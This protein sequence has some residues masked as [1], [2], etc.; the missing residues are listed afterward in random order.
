M[1]AGKDTASKKEYPILIDSDLEFIDKAKKHFDAKDYTASSIYIRKELEKIV[2]ERLP[3]ELKY[4]TDGTFLSLQTLWT[5]LVG[6]FSALGKPISE[7]TKKSFNETKLMVLNPQAH[8]QHISMPVY[9][10]EFATFT[11]KRT[12]NYFLQQNLLA[13]GRK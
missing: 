13:G 2:N 3:D 12:I 7:A 5:N 11:K 6:R 1:Y 10:I 9:K 8:F 4:K